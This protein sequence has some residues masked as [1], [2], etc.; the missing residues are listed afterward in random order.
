MEKGGS[1]LIML[2]EGGEAKQNTNMNYLLEQFGVS[3]NSGRSNVST[4]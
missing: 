2:G 1:L 4:L 3:V